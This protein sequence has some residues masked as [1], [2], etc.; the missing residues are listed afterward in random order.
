MKLV[1]FIRSGSEKEELGLL[2]GE[3]V[4]PLSDHGFSY[5]DMNELIC[6]STAEERAAMA[7]AEGETLPLA[8]V[9]LLSPIP[10]P[11]QDVLCLGLN[12]ADHAKE[13]SGFSS[14]AFGVE[15]AAPIFF[16]KRVSYSQGTPRS[17]AAARL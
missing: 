9:R 5:A 15:L 10:R 13:A 6:R 3:G 8:S 16:S 14:D 2:R 12:Y 17:D 7:V 1:T 4:L 11:M